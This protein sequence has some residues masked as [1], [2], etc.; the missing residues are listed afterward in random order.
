M[1][2]SAHSGSQSLKWTPLLANLE[3]ASSDVLLIIDSCHAAAS[4]VLMK[5]VENSSG[6]TTELIAACGFETTTPLQGF[7]LALATTLTQLTIPDQQLP[8]DHPVPFSAVRLHS[9][10]H[11]NL[12]QHGP[13]IEGHWPSTPV[14]L[15]LTEGSFRSSIL[16]KPLYPGKWRLVQYRCCSMSPYPKLHME[17]IWTG[18]AVYLLRKAERLQPTSM[19]NH[20]TH[21]GM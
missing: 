4:I 15:R 3:Q 10:L 9:H 20:Q 14:Y 17:Q 7:G 12:L 13:D 8:D 18:Y 2:F 6:G 21:S 1:K 19:P 5:P 16:L 11:L